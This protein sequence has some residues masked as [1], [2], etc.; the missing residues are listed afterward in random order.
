MPITDIHIEGQNPGVSGCFVHCQRGFSELTRVYG[1]TCLHLI[2]QLR[3][4]VDGTPYTTDLLV[5]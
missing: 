3:A 4:L 2:E 5:I 1:K